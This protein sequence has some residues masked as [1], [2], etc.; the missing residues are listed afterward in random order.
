VAVGR[1]CQQLADAIGR[2]LFGARRVISIDL[3]VMSHH[4]S[5]TELLGAAPGYLGHD[6]DLPLQ[7]LNQMPSSVLYLSGLERAHGS[8]TAVV[9]QALDDGYFTEANGRKIYVSDA[10]VIMGVS[11]DCADDRPIG[12][13]SGAGTR[14]PAPQLDQ[15]VGHAIVEGADIIVAQ[16]DVERALRM[17]TTADDL[18][19]DLRRRASGMGVRLVWD[20]D[21]VSHV[22][23]RGAH[24]GWRAVERAVERE[25]I[26]LLLRAAK[27]PITGSKRLLATESG[28]IDLVD[29]VEPQEPGPDIGAMAKQS[30]A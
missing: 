14:A 24:L 7:R 1:A 11:C 21:V 23:D 30:Q 8:I 18:L 13:A 19:D 9:G 20:G 17:D 29:E 3:G 25:V 15:I 4:Q 27:S 6:R 26:S 10:V 16:A 12:F 22:R 28:E 5:L 2:S